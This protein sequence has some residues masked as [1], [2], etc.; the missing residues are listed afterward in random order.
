MTK[1]SQVNFAVKTQ[2]VLKF[3]EKCQWFTKLSKAP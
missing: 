2:E 3:V 1:I